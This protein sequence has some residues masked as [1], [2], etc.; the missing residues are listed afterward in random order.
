MAV[1]NIA[2]IFAAL[3]VARRRGGSPAVIVT[4]IGLAWLMQGYGLTPLTQPWNPYLPVLW[5][6][7]FLLAVWGVCCRDVAM[8]PVAVASASVCMQSHIP[9]VAV[10]GGL[11]A[12]A[13]FATAMALARSPP[14]SPERRHIIRTLAA[15]TALLIVLWLPPI[16][17]QLTQEPGNV[18][19]LFGYFTNPPSAP[20]GIRAAVPLVLAHLDAWHIV[21]QECPLPGGF[22]KLLN[23]LQP[24]ARKGAA[25]VLVWSACFVASFRLRS[26][27]LSALHAVA[28]TG[29]IVAV[30][31]VSR[32]I[33][34]AV[35][36][37]MLSVWAIGVLVTVASMATVGLALARV[38]R[39]RRLRRAGP[40]LGAT[41]V[42]L[43]AL[44]LTLEALDVRPIAH[45]SAEQLQALL[46]RT[47]EGLE[48][49]F[50]AA[51]GREGRYLVTWFDGY[52]GGAQGFGLANELERAGFD[53][54]I[55]P[56]YGKVVGAHRIIRPRE[57]TARVHFVN[58]GFIWQMRR[59]RGARAIA[60]AD[61]RTAEERAEFARIRGHLVEVLQEL[62]RKDVIDMM[63][64]D[65]S[66]AL[67]LKPPLPP[68]VQLEFHRLLEIGEAAAV[69]IVPLGRKGKGS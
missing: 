33:G 20:L 48:S 62:G 60:R 37:V 7:L 67:S 32:I 52:Y 1:V 29:V 53:V 43:L 31:A 44:R 38:E 9:Y 34:G 19:I 59:I 65:P 8:L 11:G 14:A 4:A 23:E 50:G 63:P 41:A 68:L 28:G 61:V 2:V 25:A 13:A 12:L 66:S 46:P 3:F 27:A 30:L 39:S 22:I 57:A 35:P 16:I 10:C 47:I 42:F 45:R 21:V 69:F 26:A 58:G 24:D 15:S 49:G 55:E 56:R 17:E 6:A 5:F 54:G 40:W 36:H 64:Y 51:T 18:S